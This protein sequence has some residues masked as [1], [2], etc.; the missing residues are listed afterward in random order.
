MRRTI[1]TLLTSALV[2]GALMAPAADA[3]KKKKKPRKAQ[4]TYDSP[5]IGIGGVAGLCNGANGCAAFPLGAKEKF[6]SVNVVDSTG[7]PVYARVT[8]DLDGDGQADAATPFCG[9]TDG[10][11]PVEPGVTIN[12]FVYTVGVLPAPCQGVATSGV[13]KATFSG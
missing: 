3:A 7:T 8:Q 2:M 1:A 4:A 6:I 11:I 5:A 12:V 9:K 10:K 13:V